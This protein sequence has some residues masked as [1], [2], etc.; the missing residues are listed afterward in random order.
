MN[1]K[2]WERWAIE[3]FGSVEAARQFMADKAKNSPRNPTGKGGFGDLA[4]TDPEKAF[5]LQ[6]KGGRM[7]HQ[8]A[9]HARSHPDILDS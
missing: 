8:K 6:K 4:K 3:R 7:R 5:Q 9:R 1:K 2:R